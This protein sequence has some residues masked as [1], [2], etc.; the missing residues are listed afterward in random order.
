MEFCKVKFAAIVSIGKC[1][2]RDVSLR[3]VYNSNTI[4]P[5][6]RQIIL[7]KSALTKHFESHLTVDEASALSIPCTEDLVVVFLLG[8]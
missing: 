1:P 5:D 7:V 4:I 8:L 2:G 6:T 3:L